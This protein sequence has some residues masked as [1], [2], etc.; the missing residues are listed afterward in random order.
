MN[1]PI[2]SPQLPQQGL[3]SSNNGDTKL[4]TTK[5]WETIGWKC[6]RCGISFLGEWA[7]WLGGLGGGRPHH[8]RQC[9]R[10]ICNACSLTFLPLPPRYPDPVRVCDDCAIELG[11]KKNL[12]KLPVEILLRVMRMLGP[13]DLFHLAQCNRTLYQISRDRSLSLQR[14]EMM[15]LWEAKQLDKCM[16][17]KSWLGWAWKDNSNLQFQF[18]QML[19]PERRAKLFQI[20]LDQHPNKV[21]IIAEMHDSSTTDVKRLVKILAPKNLRVED[22]LKEWRRRANDTSAS[23]FPVVEAGKLPLGAS[24]AAVYNKFKHEDGFLYIKM[25]KVYVD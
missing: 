23:F 15:Y 6:G 4:G 10:C 18:K 9:G 7:Q 20:I 3:L 25:E 5:E 14:K 21:P 24:I 2:D 1:S 17:S 13:R 11:A 19:P 8:C 22:V 12:S 16:E